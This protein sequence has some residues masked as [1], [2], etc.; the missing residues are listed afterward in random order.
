MMVLAS[1]VLSLVFIAAAM[2]FARR[3]G[4][5]RAA[6]ITGLYLA[7]RPRFLAVFSLNSVGQYVDVLALGGVALAL[8][9]LLQDEP[10]PRERLRALAVGLL[11]GAAFWQQPVALSYAITVSFALALRRGAGIAAAPLLPAAAWPWASCRDR[12]EPALRVGQRRHPGARCLGLRAQVDALP[13]SPP[14]GRTSFP[15]WPA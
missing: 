15:S 11:L 12:L 7:L 8:A 9:A 3:I 14:D 2:A 1:V 13:F 10:S 4:G 6:I 5:A